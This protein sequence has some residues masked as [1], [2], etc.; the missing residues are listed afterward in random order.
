MNKRRW[1][2]RCFFRNDEDWLKHTNP[3]SIWTRFATLPFLVFAIW[4][5]VWIGLYSLLPVVLIIIW[6][7][8]N[9][10]L[11]SV[12]S[13]QRHWGSKAVL[14]ERYWLERDTHSIPNHHKKMV[15]LLNG[16]QIISTV[17]L[18]IGIWQ[19]HLWL[20]LCAMIMVYFS[21]M[22]FLDRIVWIYEDLQRD[23][24]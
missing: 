3:W 4:S 7:W 1:I 20:T 21:K 17:F 2:A 10:T 18:V 16:L 24:A 9:P 11:F 23:Q 12:P 13:H 6:L 8:L 15:Y 14:G 22:W 5:H 19:T